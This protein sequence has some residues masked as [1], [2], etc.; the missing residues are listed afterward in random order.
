MSRKNTFDLVGAS[1]HS[2]SPIPGL[3]LSDLLWQLHVDRD[4]ADPRWLAYLLAGP[5]ARRRISTQ[6][7]GTSGSMKGIVKRRILAMRIPFPPQG[8]QRWIVEVLDAAA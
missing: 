2:P 1:V 3:Y 4:K 6:A 7:S 5:E 8:R